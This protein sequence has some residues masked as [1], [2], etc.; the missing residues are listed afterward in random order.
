MRASRFSAALA[1]SVRGSTAALAAS[2]GVPVD[3]WQP[4]TVQ[5]LVRLERVSE[6]AASPDGKRVAYTLR[7]TEME[8][9]KART[10]IWLVDTGKR[11]AVPMRLTDIAANSSAAEWSADGR[12]IYFLSNRSG[13][14][15]VWRGAAGGAGPPRPPPRLRAPRRPAP[16]AAA[17]P[18]T[19]PPPP[20]GRASRASHTD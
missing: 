14:T 10:G 3:Q 11:A 2:G 15:Q 16:P 5:D 17:P 8:A 4:F 1:V 6:L 7:T 18:R 19:T 13:S 20:L 9:N 12:F